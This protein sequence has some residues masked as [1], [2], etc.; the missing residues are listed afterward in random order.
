MRIETLENRLIFVERV[1][2]QE[3]DISKGVNA[4]LDPPDFEIRHEL[5]LTTISII[6]IAVLEAVWLE[7]LVGL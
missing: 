5:Q 4:S 7:T 1:A 6:L 2:R 3:D